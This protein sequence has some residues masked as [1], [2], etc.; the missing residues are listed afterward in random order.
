MNHPEADYTEI[1]RFLGCHDNTDHRDLRVRTAFSLR[2]QGISYIVASGNTGYFHLVV[3]SDQMASSPDV[4]LVQ[5]VFVSEI[6]ALEYALDLA[7]TES[8]AEL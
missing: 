4:E 6:E 8:E 1:N 7:R 3:I 5:M 2:D